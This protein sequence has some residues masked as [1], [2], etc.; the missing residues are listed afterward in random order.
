MT[1]TADSESALFAQ[2]NQALLP[3][4]AD[5]SRFW[6]YLTSNNLV[7]GVDSPVASKVNDTVAAAADAVRRMMDHGSGG[8]SSTD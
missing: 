2:P 8:D 3:S 1:D 6:R 4:N 5:L 7:G